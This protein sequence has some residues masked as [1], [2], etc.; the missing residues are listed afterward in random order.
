MLNAQL[1]YNSRI[2]FGSPLEGFNRKL[3]QPQPS[4][5]VLYNKRGGD[6]KGKS[7]PF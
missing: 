7:I 4:G 3:L 2:P 6:G 5:A 1:T